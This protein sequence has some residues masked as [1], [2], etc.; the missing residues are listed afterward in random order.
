MA[1]LSLQLGAEAKFDSITEEELDRFHWYCAQTQGAI[2][3]EVF[4]AS[5]GP[6]MSVMRPN[7]VDPDEEAALLDWALRS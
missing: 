7:F 1:C 5:P 2:F 6:R 3:D 4:R